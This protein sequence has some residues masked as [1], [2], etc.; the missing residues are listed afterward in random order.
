[1]S[2]W[3]ITQKLYLSSKTD[4]RPMPLAVN[5]WQRYVGRM[6]LSAPSAEIDGHGQ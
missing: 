6:D 5:I 2:K 1:M 4:F 3:K